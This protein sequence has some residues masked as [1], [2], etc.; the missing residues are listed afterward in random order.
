MLSMSG[1]STDVELQRQFRYEP[2]AAT[3][4]AFA[5]QLRKLLP[6][7][8]KKFYI[9]LLPRTTLNGNEMGIHYWR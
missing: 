2:T 9:G 3:V 7:V 5:Q 8:L 6:S 4:S 1:Q